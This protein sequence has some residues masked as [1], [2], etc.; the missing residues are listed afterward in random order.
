[1]LGVTFVAGAAAGVA[2][3]RFTLLPGSA[4]AE[5][6]TDLVERRGGGRSRRQTT[7][8]RFADELELTTQQRE[9][10]DAVLEHYRASMKQVWSDV[11]PKYR[12]LV[13]SVRLEIEALLNP[14]Q[15]EQYRTLLRSQRTRDREHGESETQEDR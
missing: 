12:T 5:V 10:I 15:V 14:E 4:R 2:A 13:D 7:I 3:D 1:L 11:R 6:T 9:D 8:E